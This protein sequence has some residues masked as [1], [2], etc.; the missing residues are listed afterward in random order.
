MRPQCRELELPIGDAEAGGPAP[1]RLAHLG[2]IPGVGA[3][4]LLLL[5][6][7]FDSLADVYGASMDELSRAVGDVVAARIRWFLDAPL[8]AGAV[9][10]ATVAS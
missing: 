4:E 9:L 1:Q 8:P 5:C 2:E 6:R 10:P 3:A 7:A